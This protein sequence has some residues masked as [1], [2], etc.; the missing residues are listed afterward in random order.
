MSDKSMG[1]WQEMNNGSILPPQ[2][3]PNDITFNFVKYLVAAI[4]IIIPFGVLL[5]ITNM[6]I[7]VSILG[8][9]VFDILL[10]IIA[11]IIY[12]NKQNGNLRR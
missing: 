2:K 3:R 7:L 10:I 4:P 9:I 6:D 11:A 8:T 5:Y 1:V 12:V